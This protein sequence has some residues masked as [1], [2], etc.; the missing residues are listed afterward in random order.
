MYKLRWDPVIF[1]DN[2]I[3]VM[4]L[5]DEKENPDA[6]DKAMSNGGLRT[7]LQDSD[8]KGYWKPCTLDTGHQETYISEIVSFW[9]DRFLGFYHTPPV[10]PRYFTRLQMNSLARISEVRINYITS[11]VYYVFLMYKSIECSLSS[12]FRSISENE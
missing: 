5:E 7:Y 3:G 12:R 8:T 6:R 11:I 10:I 9:V 1:I 4:T 2:I